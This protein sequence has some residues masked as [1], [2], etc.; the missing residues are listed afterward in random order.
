LYKRFWWID[1]LHF[2][3]SVGYSWGGKRVEIVTNG[4]SE[5]VYTV[6]EIN[7][8]LC[9]ELQHHVDHK[10]WHLQIY[11][12]S[13]SALILLATGLYV[14]LS[15]ILQQFPFSWVAGLPLLLLLYL[16]LNRIIVISYRRSPLEHRARGAEEQAKDYPILTLT[17]THTD[18]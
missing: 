1:F 7:G 10:D 3:D 5:G 14:L 11:K 18:E 8:V 17:P 9:H 12:Y 16:V 4:I 6:E 15:R 2:F 13:V